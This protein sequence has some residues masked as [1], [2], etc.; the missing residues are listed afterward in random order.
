[1]SLSPHHPCHSLGTRRQGGRACQELDVI[2]IQEAGIGVVY[3]L[4]ALP[5]PGSM[6]V[7]VD[8]NGL[9]YRFNEGEDWVFEPVPNAV[10]FTEYIPTIGHELYIE[11]DLANSELD[12]SHCPLAE[13]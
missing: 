1:M 4:S 6:Q 12:C 9:I 10:A 7:S 2:V 3:H 5:C 11:Y 8:I 13:D